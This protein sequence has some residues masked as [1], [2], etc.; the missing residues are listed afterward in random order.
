MIKKN[1]IF[2]MPLLIA[3][4]IIVC[5]EREKTKLSN[6]YPVSVNGKW[7]Y[8]DTTGKTVIKPQFDGAKDFSEGLAA[9]KVGGSWGY[10]DKTGKMVIKP[11][12]DEAHGF[13]NGLAYV[14]EGNYTWGYINSAGKY[15]WK[16]NFQLSWN[17]YYI[18]FRYVAH[19]K[20]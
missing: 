2:L 18:Y 4:N 7:G 20:W 5:K 13:S 9:V 16:T 12:F 6:L 14:R 8:I 10:I 11:L 3:L 17:V 15:I 1:I 19:S